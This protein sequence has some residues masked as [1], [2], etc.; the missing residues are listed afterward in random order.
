MLRRYPDPD[1][2]AFVREG[3]VLEVRGAQRVARHDDGRLYGVHFAK[4]RKSGHPSP[5]TIFLASELRSAAA[6]WL[7]VRVKLNSDIDRRIRQAC[8][9]P[10]LPRPITQDESVGLP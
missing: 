3:D 6:R 10:G 4:R 8:E 2:F 1:W 9:C 7:G 5:D